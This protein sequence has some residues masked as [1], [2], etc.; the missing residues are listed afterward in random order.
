MITSSATSIDA[1]FIQIPNVLDQA[2]DLLT[3]RGIMSG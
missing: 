1:V 2:M 3:K